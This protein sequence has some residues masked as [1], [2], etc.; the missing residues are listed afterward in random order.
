MNLAE[1]LNV[2][3]PELPARGI[4]RANLRL[5]PKLIAREQIEGGVPTIVATVSG[6]SYVMRFSPEQWKLLQLFNGERSYREATDVFRGETGLDVSE[7]QVREFADS[8]DEGGIWYRTSFDLATTAGEKLADERRRRAKKKIDLSMMTFSTWDPDEYLTRLYR[9]LRFVYTKWFTFLTL[10]VF[11]IMILIFVNGW[12]EIWRDT[13]RYYTFTDKSAADLAEFWLLFCGLGFFHESAHGLTCKH[14]GGGVHSMGFM[15]VYL[16]PAFFCDVGE[17]YVYGGKW[18]RVAAI[19]AGIWVEL[20][21]C[22]A[23][24]IVWWGTPAGSPIHDFAYKI[25]LITGVAVVLMNLNPLIKLDG[26]YLFGELVGVPTIKE[27]STA[28]LSSWVKFHLFNLP[29]DVPYM[30]PRRRWLFA[31]YALISGLYSYVVLFAVVHFVYNIFSRSSPQWAFLPALLLALLIFRSRLRSSL[32]FMKD[33]YLDKQ[34]NLRMLRNQPY[35]IG[36][37]LLAAVLLLFAPIWRET[38]SGRFV[39]EPIRRETIRSAVP[40]QIT[41]VLVGEGTPVVEGT[42]LFVLTNARLEG[43]ADEAKGSLSVAEARAREAL[44]NHASLGSAR[45]ERISQTGRFRSALE[46]VGA[47]QVSSPIAGVVSTARLRDRLGSFVEAGD[48]LAEVDDARMFKA[49]I[50][51]PEFQVRKIALR[52]PVSLKLE[53]LVRPVRGP[54]SSLAPA[55][56]ELGPGLEQQKKYQGIAPPSYYAA[57]VLLSNVDGRLRSGMSG[58]AKIQV[59]R[60]SMAGSGWRTFREFLQR[61]VW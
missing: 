49:R 46:Q 12:S 48:V 6:G 26:Y 3:L 59:R 16:S 53:G 32:R 40:G 50:F 42:P 15:L 57:E 22:S 54:V 24:S 27:N 41:E 30:R 4:G 5:H 56:S 9:H 2:A 14:F 37:A 11:A 38:V 1:V 35:R 21:F 29:V 60:Q 18:P 7:E 34:Q 19:I 58:E 28:Y 47:L 52:A 55:S 33:F 17:V 44:I 36:A 51:I 10:G 61:K 31:S 43:E 13:V 45:A 20:M 8:L 39:L 23:A 25:M